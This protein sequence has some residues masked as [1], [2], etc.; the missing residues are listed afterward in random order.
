MTLPQALRI[1]HAL[2][3]DI[4]S[5][6]LEVTAHIALTA[7]LITA[8]LLA[9]CASMLGRA[10]ARRRLRRQ[11]RRDV[12]RWRDLEAWRQASRPLTEEEIARR[13]DLRRRL[14]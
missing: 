4:A 3:A 12:A 13:A 14:K 11:C 6:T 5:G 7:L 2:I 8:A 9:I 10:A 1:A